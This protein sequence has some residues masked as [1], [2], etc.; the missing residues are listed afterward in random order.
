[1]RLTTL[2]QSY[3]LKLPQ[4]RTLQQP[5]EYLKSLATKASTLL[6]E[7]LWSDDWLD[8]FATESKKKAYKVI[9]EQQ[10]GV[11]AHGHPLYLPSRIRRCIAERVGRILRSQV[12][13]RAC[14]RDV[15]QVVQITGVAGNLDALVKTVASFIT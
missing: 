3:P 8:R 10:V 13:R 15:L 12:E 6:L 2:I 4:Y 1:M 5:L 7:K 11:T 9:G 14:Y